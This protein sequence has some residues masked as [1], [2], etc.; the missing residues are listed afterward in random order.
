MSLVRVH[1]FSISLDGFGTGEPQPREDRS[2]T[3]AKGCTSGC[4]PPGGGEARWPASPAAAASSRR[5]R[6]A[7]RSRDRRRDHG[8]QQFGPPGWHEDPEWKGWWGPNPPFHTP[9]FVLT[10][11]TRQPIEMEGGTTFHFL[12]APPAEALETAREAADGKD[13]RIGGGPPW[14]ATSSPTGWSTTCTRWSPDPARPRRTPLGR[15]GGHRERLRDRG[16]LL[17]ERSHAPDIHP[18]GSEF[19]RVGTRRGRQ[20]LRE[21]AGERPVD[22]HLTGCVGSPFGAPPRNSVALGARPISAMQRRTAARMRW[23][24]RARRRARLRLLPRESPSLAPADGRGLCRVRPP[25]ERSATSRTRLQWCCGSARGDRPIGASAHSPQRFRGS[26]CSQPT[27]PAHF[28]RA[29]C[30]AYAAGAL[31]QI[32]SG[33][34]PAPPADLDHDFAAHG[35]GRRFEHH[36][37]PPT[38][39]HISRTPA[40]RELVEPV[41]EPPEVLSTSNSP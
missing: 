24:L 20:H 37:F 3:P 6:A 27:A 35:R 10:H 32:Q 36:E 14:S 13:I 5:L 8:C 22:R 17:T 21:A 26:R 18:L 33:L 25:R 41:H 39:I 34:E 7:V 11:H 2:A 12:D 38:R 31:R 28:G 9:T 40:R 19:V 15:T 23:R 4:S 16:D 29:V 30:V 1:N